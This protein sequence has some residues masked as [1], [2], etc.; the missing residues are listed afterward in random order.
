MSAEQPTIPRKTL[1]LDLY[2]SNSVSLRR[3]TASPA[4]VHNT[5]VILNPNVR[6]SKGQMAGALNTVVTSP[7]PL[8][9]MQR[10]LATMK[11]AASVDFAFVFNL[12]G[13]GRLMALWANHTVLTKVSNQFQKLH[14]FSVPDWRDVTPSLWLHSV[15]VAWVLEDPLVPFCALI[16]YL[17]T[18][19][20][21]LEVDMRQ[22]FLTDWPI[23]SLSQLREKRVNINELWAGPVKTASSLELC[24][25]AERYQLWDL[26]AACE[27]RV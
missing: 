6:A 14:R 13:S 12:C 18:G 21:E 5:S 26:C 24:E 11:D 2:P 19:R 27:K 22:F 10:V 20:L 1:Q 9:E 4:K 15:F 23:Q 8:G 16:H 3:R 17:Y 7:V 25:L